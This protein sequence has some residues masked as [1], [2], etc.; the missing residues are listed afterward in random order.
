MKNRMLFRIVLTGAF[1]SQLLAVVPVAQAW[2]KP[3][4]L[5]PATEAAWINAVKRHK[6]RDGATVAEVLAYAEKMRPER[7]KAGAIEI[8]YSGANGI[9][10]AVTIGYWIGAKRLPDDSFVDLGYDMN[11][12]GTFKLVTPD[13]TT[14]VALDGGRD[15]F[16]KAM[17]EAYQD[18]CQPDADEPP[19]C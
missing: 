14:L 4:V 11:P 8:G 6:T 3:K 15:S 2:P 12:D 1:F 18:I 19:T 9:A 7:F 16:L 17:D 10:S 5:P 13:E